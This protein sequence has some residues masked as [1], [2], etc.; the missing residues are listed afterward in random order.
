MPSTRK[1]TKI[2]FLEEYPTEKLLGARLPTRS[3]VFRFFFYLHHVLSNS[4]AEAART[5]VQAAKFF[6]VSAGIATKKDKQAQKDMLKIN[7]IFKVC[8]KERI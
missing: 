6:W 5:A 8:D 3:D 2:P 7:M 4:L 1:D